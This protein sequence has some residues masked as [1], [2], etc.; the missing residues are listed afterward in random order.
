VISNEELKFI[1]AIQDDV[2]YLILMLKYNRPVFLMEL[3]TVL[4]VPPEQAYKRLKY[5]QKINLVKRVGKELYVLTRP[6]I[7][8]LYCSPFAEPKVS[9]DPVKDLPH[10][11]YF[12][13]YCLR[14]ALASEPLHEA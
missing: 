5:L 7:D 6:A 3:S 13:R 12:D 10:M 2:I 14:R 11:R 1:R 4:K 9:P 8:F